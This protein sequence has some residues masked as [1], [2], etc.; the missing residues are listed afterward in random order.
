MGLLLLR[1][2]EVGLPKSLEAVDSGF[3]LL[4]LSGPE[5]GTPHKI[6][7]GRST[8]QNPKAGMGEPGEIYVAGLLGNDEVAL[9]VVMTTGVAIALLAL[10]S[11]GV[12]AGYQ[13][14]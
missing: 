7:L 3:R 9:S 6:P 1:L 13:D 10:V 11:V 2:R 12:P 14:T 8:L 5:K 4:V